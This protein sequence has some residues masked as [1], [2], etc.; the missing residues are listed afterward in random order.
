MNAET[1]SAVA[2]GEARYPL[3]FP[4]PVDGGAQ[5]SELVFRE[6]DGEALEAIDELGIKEGP[7]EQPSIKQINML[8]SILSGQPIEIV[9]KMN[10]RDIEGAS[11]A[12]APLLAEDG[13]TSGG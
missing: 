4:V 3:L 10:K 12:F 8:I 9:R 13:E 2:W 11:K 5:I 7:N 1:N 6:P